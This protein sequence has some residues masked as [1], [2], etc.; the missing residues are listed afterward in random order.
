MIDADEL[1][2][3]F[4]RGEFF[5]E[6]LP[7]IS[8]TDGRCIGAEALTRWQ[9]PDGVVSPLEFIPLMENTPFSSERVTMAFWQ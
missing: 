6:Y 2:D 9:R 8:L 4:Q 5:L 3:A 1:R 7:I